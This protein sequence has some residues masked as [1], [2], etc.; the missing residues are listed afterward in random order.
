MHLLLIYDLHFTSGH[1]RFRKKEEFPPIF[2]KESKGI[3]THTHTHTGTLIVK[4][5]SITH[6]YHI[7]LSFIHMPEGAL[8]VIL[9]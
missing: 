9:G 1:L 3:H 2:L 6:F 4:Y 8:I 5:S 7:S